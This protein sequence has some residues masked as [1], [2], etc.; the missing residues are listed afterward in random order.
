MPAWQSFIIGIRKGTKLAG[1]RCKMEKKASKYVLNATTVAATTKSSTKPLNELAI[2]LHNRGECNK[3][4][5]QHNH[6]L[7]AL[8]QCHVAAI[9]L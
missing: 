2:R 1:R 5:G 7:A 9:Y 3:R 8:P 4:N 6:T